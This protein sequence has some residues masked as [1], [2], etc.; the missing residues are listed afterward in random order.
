MYLC[1]YVHTYVSIISLI[2]SNFPIPLGSFEIYTYTH[3]SEQS[4]KLQYT[5]RM[6][7]ENFNGINI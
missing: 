7:I 2:L 1:I 5:F 6:D 3:V 4:L